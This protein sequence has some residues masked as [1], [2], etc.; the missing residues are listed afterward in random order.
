MFGKL[1]Q[2]KLTEENNIYNK[3]PKM[4]VYI[5]QNKVQKCTQYFHILAKQIVCHYKIC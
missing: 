2:D 3:I 4:F 1:K 5:D